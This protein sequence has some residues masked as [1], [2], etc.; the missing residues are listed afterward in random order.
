M[1]HL[2]TVVLSHFPG[3]LFN[4]IQLD[5][6]WFLVAVFYGT[7]DKSLCMEFTVSIKE[8][9]AHLMTLKYPHN[10]CVNCKFTGAELLLKLYLIVKQLGIEEI[11]LLDMSQKY[12][13]E[14]CSV[15]LPVLSILQ[16]GMTWYNRFGY[17]GP[18][19][20]AEHAFI[21]RELHR[22]F[23]EWNWNGLWDKLN[24]AFKNI[25][26]LPARLKYRGNYT[27]DEFRDELKSEGF[28]NADTLYDVGKLLR[29]RL[30]KSDDFCKSPLFF[31]LRHLETR[32]FNRIAW[33]L[34]LMV[35]DPETVAIYAALEK[36]IGSGK[37]G[38][39]T[40]NKRPRKIRSHRFIA[41]P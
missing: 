22:P 20:D 16:Y 19:R 34:K 27:L 13:A 12:F 2:R 18:N 41:L 15:S 39:K 1:N 29:K 6:E 14:D 21:Q 36:K 5:I 10:N 35:N 31:I 9:Q 11:E 40:R 4:F 30:E 7:A 38:G 3:C 37:T 33:S 32:I 24:R 28:E 25:P 8:K 23:K 26:Y 17:Y